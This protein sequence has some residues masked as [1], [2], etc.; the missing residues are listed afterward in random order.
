[1]NA[2]PDP[3]VMTEPCPDCGRDTPH[4]VRVELRAEGGDP[5]TAAFSREPY[6]ISVC[7]VCNAEGVLRMNDA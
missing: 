1:M 5:A 4:R 7:T 3:S 6:R 2:T